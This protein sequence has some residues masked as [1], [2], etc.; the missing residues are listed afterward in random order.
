VCISLAAALAACGASASKPVT[1][2]TV[3]DSADDRNL[4]LTYGLD[5]C[6]DLDR[7]EVAYAR[8]DVTI[9]VFVVSNGRVCTGVRFL[10]SVDVP[11][12]QPLA[13]RP[14]RDGA[15]A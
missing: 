4:A 8:A 15:R 1:W 3:R 13:G 5:S 12:H 7:V 9:T 6:Q 14:V 10:R 11:L 2:Q